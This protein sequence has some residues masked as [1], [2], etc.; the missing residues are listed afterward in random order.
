MNQ[1]ATR[2]I[3]T[4][5]LLLCVPLFLVLCSPG[6]QA[7]GIV[8]AGALTG[9]VGGGAAGAAGGL[10]KALG[11]AMGGV[12]AG[13]GSASGS[14]SGGGSYRPP[15][16]GAVADFSGA[17]AAFGAAPAAA[18]EAGTSA[19][20]ASQDAAFDVGDGAAAGTPAAVGTPAADLTLATGGMNAEAPAALSQAELE[21]QVDIAA[22][23]FRKM[24]ELELVSIDPMVVATMS[25]V[26]YRGLRRAKADRFA[27]TQGSYGTAQFIPRRQLALER[28]IQQAKDMQYSQE[29][30]DEMAKMFRLK[31]YIDY[32]Y[33]VRY[34]TD[35]NA[36]LALMRKK[37]KDDLER[38]AQIRKAG[39]GITGGTGVFPELPP[40]WRGDSGGVTQDPNNKDGNK[41]LPPGAWNRDDADT[42]KRITELQDQLN[43][44]TGGGAQQIPPEVVAS[45]EAAIH[46]A[47]LEKLKGKGFNVAALNVFLQTMEEVKV[48]VIVTTAELPRS[49]IRSTLRQVRGIIETEV[50]NVKFKPLRLAQL[51]SFTILNEVDNHFYEHPVLYWQMQ[52]AG[53][54][55]H[56]RRLAPGTPAV[57]ERLPQA[58]VAMEADRMLQDF[59]GN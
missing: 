55:A 1:P 4:T 49:A 6:V 45:L 59:L 18:G 52:L 22:D 21:K 38:Y 41:I 9:A 51:S 47:V 31:D 46:N 14:A 7:Q 27:L 24:K 25:Y 5:V 17:D 39:T 23:K 37:Y 13:V 32:D 36:Y 3:V 29:L 15:S 16:G 2:S 44:W 56:G 48:I 40:D 8:E 10:G 42:Y 26:E 11:S 33:D 54:D 12:A 28:V 19:T 20:F 30:I 50:L 57:G 43:K 34:G 35:P 53:W 58:D